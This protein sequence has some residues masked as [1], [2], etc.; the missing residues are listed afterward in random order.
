MPDL[1]PLIERRLSETKTKKLLDAGRLERVLLRYPLRATWLKLFGKNQLINNTLAWNEPFVTRGCLPGLYTIGLLVDRD[2]INLSLFLVKNLRKTDVF[3]DIGSHYGFYARLAAAAIDSSVQKPTVHAFEP[4]PTTYAVV[5][6]NAR[7]RGIV[8]NNCAL[9]DHEGEA[10]ITIVKASSGS[11]SLHPEFI[12][13]QGMDSDIATELVHLTTLDRYC[14]DNNLTP[15]YMKIDAEGSE[16]E[17]IRGGLKTIAA[18]KPTIVMEFWPMAMGDAHYRAL[19][20]LSTLGY[21]V[22][23]IV[24]GGALESRDLT[25]FAD[26]TTSGILACIPTSR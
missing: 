9:S 26:V 25:Y 18:T 19:Q 16:Y 11:N 6:E 12:A 23:E 15:T 4:T 7:D 1:L 8:V 21:S 2:E 17:V 13:N 20:E 22:N 3:M 14:A 10:T 5:S 24:E